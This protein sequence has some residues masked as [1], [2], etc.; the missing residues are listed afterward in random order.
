MKRIFTKIIT[1]LI[2]LFACNAYA[3]KGTKAMLSNVDTIYLDLATNI[4]PTYQV[5]NNK[6]VV[7]V[8]HN[9]LPSGHYAVNQT[10][11]LK[12]SGSLPV[13]AALAAT[14]IDPCT[15]LE[16]ALHDA[17]TEAEIGQ[18]MTIARTNNCDFYGKYLTATTSD[19]I[20]ISK[21]NNEVFTL[22]ITNLDTKRDWT[23]NIQTEEKG[24]F[25]TVYGFTYIPFVF[26]KPHTYYAQQNLD[27]KG[28]PLGTYTVA[29]GS[30][31]S[32]AQYAPTVAFHYITKSSGVLSSSFTAGLGVSLSSNA[33]G[34]SPVVIAGYSLLYNQNIGINFGVAAH[35]VTNLKGEFTNGQ[36]LYSGLQ[37]ND[38]N[39]QV[40]RFNPFFS[41][42]FRFG[43]NPFSAKK[44]PANSNGT[45]SVGTINSTSNTGALKK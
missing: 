25:V 2:V 4:S 26:G 45:I 42:I 8:I 27:S 7:I 35:Q 14:G 5:P 15:G 13:P 6:P 36:L 30:S 12:L 34:I 24:Q 38:L 20:T 39:E 33:T 40:T 37:G 32:Q 29:P 3:Q 41:I 44:L 10:R 9:L 23:I 31:E 16:Q 22:T 18:L 19:P 28:A 11:S 17:K 43:S 21:L 1:L